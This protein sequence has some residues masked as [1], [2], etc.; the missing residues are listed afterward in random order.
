[1]SPAHR[2]TSVALCALIIAALAVYI[3]LGAAGFWE[4]LPPPVLF[5]EDG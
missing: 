4:P 1:M 3:I 5:T 2:P